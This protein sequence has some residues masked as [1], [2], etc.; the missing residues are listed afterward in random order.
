MADAPQ[1]QLQIPA[2]HV[3]CTTYG[4]LRHEMVTS[5]METRSHSEKNGLVNVRWY[6]VPGTLVEKARNEACRIALQ[7]QNCGWLMMVDGDMQ[8]PPDSILKMV[9]TAFGSHPHAD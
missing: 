8:F 5:W 4:V 7:D 9:G 3:C 1:G 2:G 6:T